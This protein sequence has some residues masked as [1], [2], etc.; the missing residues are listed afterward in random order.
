V[1]K[2]RDHVARPPA[3]AAE[4][5]FNRLPH[6]PPVE[7]I[8]FHQIGYHGAGSQFPRRC[9]F[10]HPPRVGGA[11]GENPVGRDFAGQ[12]W[13]SNVF[14]GD[15]HRLIEITS[16]S[17]LGLGMG[18]RSSFKPSRWNSIASWIKERTSAL[19]RPVVATP[20]K[21]GTYAA[22]PVSDFS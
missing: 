22:Q 11:A 13:T 6:R 5:A 20:G 10:H 12:R 1:G 9:D 21:S 16:A 2:D 3:D 18:N 17:A 7:Q 19:V 4:R 8:R 15:A 14:G